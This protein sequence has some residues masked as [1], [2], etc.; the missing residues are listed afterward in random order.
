[1]AVLLGAVRKGNKI[2]KPSGALRLDAGDTIV[3]FAMASDVA[4]VEQ[5]LQVSFDFF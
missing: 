2:H 4:R 1:M 5:L 3:L